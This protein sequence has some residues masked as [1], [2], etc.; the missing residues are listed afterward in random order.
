MKPITLD[1]ETYFDKDYTLSKLTTEEYVR[2]PRFKVHCVGFRTDQDPKRPVWAQTV[3]W[4]RDHAANKGWFSDCAVLCHHSQ[5]DGLILNHHYGI[6]PAFWFDTLSMAR[7]VL[8]HLK[9][10][11][12]EA[13]AA[14]FGL[15]AKTVP[16]QKFKGLRNLPAELYREV[17]ESCKLDVEL[18]YAIFRKLLPSVPAEEL[19][20]IDATI[21]M[22][23]EP[24]LGLDKPRLENYLAK[25]QD[26]KALALNKLGVTR[27]ELQSSA[28]FA[29]LLQ[30]L[31]VE[32]PTKPSPSGGV[33]LQCV[34]VTGEID[35]QCLF[36]KGSGKKQIPALSKT[37]E[38]MKQ[39]LE[40][41]NETVA[42]LAAA[43]LGQKSTLGETRSQSLLGMQDRGAL[44]VYLRYCGAHT[45][46]WS[47]ADGL[48]FQNLPRGSEIRSSILAPERSRL[49]IID[50][51][52]IE[53]RVLNWLAGQEDILTAFREGRDLYS[54][55]ASRFYGQPVTKADKL[56]RH[57]G[58]TLELGCGYGMGWAKFQHTCR[59]GALGGAPISL[60]E[61]EAR[62]AVAS[63]RAS[64]PA[65]VRLW[66]Y[67]DWMLAALHTQEQEIVWGPM[68]VRA[69]QIVLPNGAALDYSNLTIVDGEY[70]TITRKGTTKIYGAKLVEN[71]VQALSRVVLSQAMLKIIAAGWRV[72]LTCHDELVMV[73]PVEHAQECL[74][75]CLQIMKTP[76]AWAAGLPLDAEG[77]V[78]ERYS[79]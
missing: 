66:K 77:W 45:T 5:F 29:V 60:D 2:D 58:K 21:R 69:A 8:P 25:V 42:L 9:S 19:R 26:E 55:G 23:T 72:V 3:P 27:E 43:R 49:V 71:V 79:K 12:L 24:C 36:C 74:A 56:E 64:H 73:A 70:A 30:S 59:G 14:H 37:D 61:G 22:F 47:G 17:A 57:L 11:S 13:L 16:Y 53:C 4:A 20:V 52:Q 63:Y 44:C 1:I 40:H 32:C 6:R 18:T 33:C 38:G 62:R 34:G 51:A 41:E 75:E 7:L 31:G 10:H 76:P 65:V 39:L 78:S 68:R 67:A 48:N 35:L 15:P 50:L 28:K 54:E 46:R